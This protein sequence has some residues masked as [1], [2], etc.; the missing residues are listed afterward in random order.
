MMYLSKGLLVQETGGDFRV[1][2]GGRLFVLGH[3]MAALWSAARLAPQAVPDGKE[4]Y[5]ERL[6]Q[7]GLAATT[8]EAG[9][10]ANYR[11][12]CACIICPDPEGVG[13]DVGLDGRVWT[14]L[15][16]AGLRLT[17]SE[18]IRL[19]ELGT[20][21][22]PDLLGEEGRQ[23]LT[24]RIYDQYSIFDGV[25]E[26]RMEQSPARDILV[27]SLLRLLRAGSLFLV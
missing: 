24:E 12:L 20:E 3:E 11:L 2:R 5:V 19:E 10:L 16:R 14:W 18:L 15:Q 7:S 17:V 9:D 4:R 13:A 22:A 6:E 21:P 23:N 25:L 27:A 26:P 8:E 1:S